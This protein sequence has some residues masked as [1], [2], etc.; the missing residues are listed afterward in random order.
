[1]S[2][3]CFLQ[4]YFFCRC[5]AWLSTS[6]YIECFQDNAKETLKETYNITQSTVG[7]VIATKT[8]QSAFCAAR[9]AANEK[10]QL[11]LSLVW[12]ASMCIWPKRGA[13]GPGA[14]SLLKCVHL[15][16][17]NVGKN[18]PGL[19]HDLFEVF[20]G[21]YAGKEEC[22]VLLHERERLREIVRELF[23]WATPRTVPNLFTSAW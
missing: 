8:S 11:F 15:Y 10:N 2:F 3:P 23:D 21:I 13:C 7:E 5:T 9:C 18:C 6:A 4:T 16:T 12:W 20:C 14:N 1:M 17:A 19:K 22:I